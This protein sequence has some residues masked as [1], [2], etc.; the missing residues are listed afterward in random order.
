MQVLLRGKS[1]VPSNPLRGLP[2]RLMAFAS[3]FGRM[4]VAMSRARLGLFVLARKALFA[5]CAD[6]RPTFA[7]LLERPTTLHI[8][9]KETYGET[10]R[11]AQ[12]A[13]ESVPITMEDLTKSVVNKVQAWEKEQKKA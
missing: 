8:V 2:A 13:R 4:V 5:P 9:P 3:G 11:E 10:E 6:L 12:A 7:K 1:L